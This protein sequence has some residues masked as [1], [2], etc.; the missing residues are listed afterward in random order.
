MQSGRGERQMQG[1]TWGNASPLQGWQEQR[2]E[3]AWTRGYRER[4][5][6]IW[7]T[8]WV[9]R[10]KAELKF[11]VNY[12]HGLPGICSF[13]QPNFHWALFAVCQTR[14]QRVDI[15]ICK[16]HGPLSPVWGRGWGETDT[17][18]IILMGCDNR[19]YM[20]CGHSS[21]TLG[22]HQRITRI[23][24]H[25]WSYHIPVK[26][27]RKKKRTKGPIK[28][29]VSIRLVAKSLHFQLWKTIW[30]KV[31]LGVTSQRRWPARCTRWMRCRGSKGT[32]KAQE[33]ETTFRNLK[34]FGVA[35]GQGVPV[36]SSTV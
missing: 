1:Q 29:R 14:F 25:Q 3:G 30:R 7:W 31:S 18:Q 11:T 34:S 12:D 35:K 17:T 4:T 22:V 36:S 32:A 33:R 13:I 6:C 20:R 27:E 23:F 5:D 9:G 26:N 10:E 16:G 28:P 24:L 2:G 21:G 19:L 15:H 8:V